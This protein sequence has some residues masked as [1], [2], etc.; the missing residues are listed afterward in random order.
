MLFSFYSVF[1][2]LLSCSRAWIQVCECNMCMTNTCSW[3]ARPRWETAQKPAGRR[4]KNASKLLECVRHQEEL[5]SSVTR[6]PTKVF[7][8]T[9]EVQIIIYFLFSIVIVSL[10]LF[11]GQMIWIIRKVAWICFNVSHLTF[12]CLL[13]AAWNARAE[14]VVDCWST[15]TDLWTSVQL[16]QSD[17]Q[18]WHREVNPA[19]PLLPTFSVGVIMSCDCMFGA[20]KQHR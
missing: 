5:A 10:L 4:S 8:H 7:L 15:C 9:Y 2:E 16:F 6:A 19:F 12:I 18:V 13:N 1:G 20:C 3:L 14:S 11:A 17:S